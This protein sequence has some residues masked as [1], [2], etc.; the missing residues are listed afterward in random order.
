VTALDSAHAHLSKAREVLEAA[1]ASPELELHNAA[2]SNAVISGINSKD[3]ICLTLVGRS[4]R[5]DN[6]DEAR[7][8]LRVAGP[9]GQALEPTLGRLLRLKAKAQYQQG[10]VTASDAAKA[11]EWATRLQEGAHE[12]VIG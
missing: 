1:E 8:E 4:K 7:Q 9:A 6:H 2:V 5:G 11:V 12:V 3:A 10:S